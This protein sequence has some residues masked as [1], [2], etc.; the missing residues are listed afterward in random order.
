VFRIYHSNKLDVLKGIL[1]HLLKHD[2]LRNPFER[3]KILVQSPGMAQWLKMELAQELG[4]CANIE[5]PLPASFIWQT[6]VDVLDDVPKRSAFNKDAMAWQ[7][8]TRLPNFLERDEFSELA[9]Y[10][11]D[12]EPLK[13]YQLA[14]KIADIYDQYL[15]YRPHWI[16]AWQQG[17]VTY[18]E[19]Q[20]WQAILWQDLAQGI[21]DSGQ[22]HYHRAN[23]YE[24][25]I[26]ALAHLDAAHRL[27]LPKRIF[28]F[29]V[30]ALPPK[31]LEALQAI[32]QH[33]EVHFFLNN[34]CQVYWG[35][36]VDQRWL[37]KL[38]G[39]KRQSIAQTMAISSINV[40]QTNEPLLPLDSESLFSEQGE[41]I[42]G[43]PLLASMGKLGRD[44]QALMLELSAQ[45]IEAFSPSDTD[46]YGQVSLLGAINDDILNL[47]DS[48]FIGTNNQQ[49]AQGYQRKGI[50]EHD[51]SIAIHNCHSPMREIEVLHDQV[52][53][54]LAQDPSLTPKD[55]VVMM[56]DVNAYSPYIQAVFS[57]AKHRI[58]FSISD[59]SVKQENPVLLS[60]LTLLDLTNLRQTSNELFNLLEVPAIMAQ[61]GLSPQS[62]KRVKLWIEQS[63]IRQ[64]LGQEGH[65]QDNSWQFGLNRMF[66]GY[67]QSEVSD[68]ASPI[69]WQ[70]ILAY[71][72]S[73]GLVAD[74][75][76]QLALF[77]ERIEHYKLL[78]TG[79]K[80]FEQW[81]EI[82]EQLLSDFYQ[83]S[84]ETEQ[85]LRIINECLDTLAEQLVL[86]DF[87][88]DIASEVLFEHLSANLAAGQSSQRFL[89]GK[90][91]FC[92]L[93][94]M[95]S[96]PFK[97]VCVL[98]MNDGVYPRTIAPL[99]FDLMAN[100]P[101]K[102]DRCRRDD[103]RYLFLEALLSA[104]QRF[105]ISYCG[106]H[107]KDNSV[108][109]PS[110]LVN[111]LT[112]YISQSFRLEHDVDSD[113]NQCSE[114]I[115]TH[116]TTV[117]PLVPFNEMYYKPNT[118]K[119]F[120]YQHD[121]ISAVDIALTS[122]QFF[123]APLRLNDTGQPLELEQLKRF[124]KQ[125]C[126]YFLNQRL[127][128]YFGQYDTELTDSEPF[129]PDGLQSY[130]IKSN[131]LDSYLKGDSE[132]QIARLR[133]EGILPHGHFAD[134][135][136]SDHTQTMTTLANDV[137][138]YVTTPMDDIQ[139]NLLIEPTA[140]DMPDE[141]LA[142]MSDHSAVQIQG[143][144]KQRTSPNSL[145]RY[146]SG[147][148]NGKFFIDC[149][150]DYLAFCATEHSQ[151]PGAM[152]MITQDGQWRF[153]PF[154]PILARQ[155]LSRLLASYLVGAT[156]PLPFFI[157]SGWNY[158]A[159]RFD[160]KSLELSNDEK[161]VA[162][163]DKAL[164]DG[165]IGNDRVSGEGENP[166]NQ[167]CF[168]N[169]LSES[170]DQLISNS[171]ALLLPIFIHI[172]ELS[173]E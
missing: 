22:S 139:I 92:T 148:A 62:L 38:Q 125:P 146:K 43:N 121:W 127:G 71:E 54:M 84:L 89:A 173:D 42:V 153:S 122:Q 168:P 11:M 105:Y 75:L 169:V 14:Y 131:L 34:P 137:K 129:E 40:T 167:R 65:S 98:G 152:F 51:Q 147:K 160:N 110:V 130:L 3:E 100:D 39:R 1:T 23:L 77:I 28:V 99:G 104:Q 162:K 44:N 67:S 32:G 154:T 113:L 33:C 81:R 97:V 66:K 101:Q 80:P 6:F 163:A 29:G 95:R 159:A 111:E 27:K 85:E 45:E 108:R 106:H 4:V 26:D 134:L 35:D 143:W 123:Q 117:H 52:L 124:V 53:A 61:F 64:G 126:Q 165:I 116:M 9:S 142:Q 93:M 21:V 91:N 157:Q 18:S 109:C 58:D 72:E 145:I 118:H 36:I 16:K 15:V 141:L 7:I 10:L 171:I 158:I 68:S 135:L 60:F 13:L 103:D 55:I 2:P 73:S 24:H 115:L 74:D 50:S 83:E 133:A 19:E 102:G 76:G 164:N 107:I 5:F 12:D 156:T 136:L 140:D 57:S 128:V 119:L 63:G 79:S 120:S 138:P 17:D 20:Q 90:L 132:H 8:I 25:L 41:L 49:L 87:S 78:L 82:L 170:R 47:A 114:N 30:S 96:I 46:K 166:Y 112:E 88:L 48:S 149:Y 144:L 37:S 56:P 86:A 94:P 69:L 161:L 150:I 59:R 31:Y 151:E 70:D 155:H 172:E